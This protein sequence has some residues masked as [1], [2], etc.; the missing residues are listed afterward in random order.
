MQLIHGVKLKPLKVIPDERGRL[1]EMLRADDE[2]YIKFG[3]AYLTTAYPGVVK[4]WHYHKQQAD[5]LVVVK[6]MMKVALYDDRAG[7]PTRGLVH[8]EDHCRAIDLVL[9]QGSPGEI[10]NI[11]GDHERTNI[12]IVQTILR[13]LGKPKKLINF[14]RDRPGHDHR[15]AIDATK[16]SQNINLKSIFR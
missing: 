12:E 13:Y 3:Q 10:Y 16:E 7:S 9:R 8:V 6:G 2:L 11:G 1:M 15:Y 14:V 5:N 4:A